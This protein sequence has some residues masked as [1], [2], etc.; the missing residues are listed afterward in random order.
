[1]G[2]TPEGQRWLIQILGPKLG[3]CRGEKNNSDKYMNQI[4]PSSI[5]HSRYSHKIRMDN[6]LYSARRFA[7]GTAKGHFFGNQV[8]PKI[9]PFA[10]LLFELRLGSQ[11]DIQ[12]GP[13]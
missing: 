4:F 1:M 9:W 13:A 11:F 7:T 2:P 12:A 10:N 6:D 8:L 5:P 3:I